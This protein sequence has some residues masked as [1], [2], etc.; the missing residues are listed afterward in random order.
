MD[1]R[2]L[3]S[4]TLMVLAT[5][6]SALAAPIVVVTSGAQRI[7]TFDSG[8]PGVLSSNQLITGLINGDV[9]NAIDR[10]PSDG[11]IYGLTSNS[12]R[13]YTINPGTGVATFVANAGIGASGNTGFDF[14]P[15][16][17]SAGFP[18]L[19][20]SGGLISGTTA[21]NVRITIP[22]GATLTDS[23]FEFA[24]G[25]PNATV[26]PIIPALAY[27]NNVPGATA[28]SLYGLVSLPGGASINPP[29]LVQIPNPAAGSMNT[30]GSLGVPNLNSLQGF[31]IAS[32]GTAYA[33]IGTPGGSQLFTINLGTG[34]A[35]LVGAI[36]SP[37]VGLAASVDLASPVPEPATTMLLSTSLA[38]LALLRRRLL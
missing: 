25:D 4:L 13:I 16:A 22:T 24:P 30:I 17:D 8:T 1:R 7:Q 32:D 11:L 26:P 33:A 27:T 20:V 9:I 2:W 31:D 10:R 18:S 34:Q 5:G 36:G 37:V 3:F 12:N 35:T 29:V 6:V 19:R 23:P 15:V 28:T 14:N 21:H 38:A